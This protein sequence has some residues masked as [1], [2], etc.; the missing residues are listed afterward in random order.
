MLC[1]KFRGYIPLKREAYP[2]L[3]KNIETIQPKQTTDSLQYL[4]QQNG[5]NKR[6]NESRNQPSENDSSKTN[7]NLSINLR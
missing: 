4:F 2:A 3:N 1:S 5:D 6:R 7:F